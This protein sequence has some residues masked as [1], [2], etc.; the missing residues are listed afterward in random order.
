M[1]ETEFRLIVWDW[2]ISLTKALE[3]VIVEGT[4]NDL[5]E[6]VDMTVH[7]WD[8]CEGGCRHITA[9]VASTT[10][11]EPPHFVKEMLAEDPENMPVAPSATD[12]AEYEASRWPVFLPQMYKL[13]EGHPDPTQNVACDLTVRKTGEESWE[14]IH[15]N[16]P[17]EY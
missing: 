1:A 2:N 4:F 13:W 6:F 14:Y 12:H 5:D 9:S 3:H 8:S 11:K 7:M 10:A 16:G 15:E 17:I